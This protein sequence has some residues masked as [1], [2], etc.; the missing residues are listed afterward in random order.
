MRRHLE[1]SKA[2]LLNYISKHPEHAAK[3][4]MAA[5]EEE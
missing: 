4:A 2:A 3:M 5:Q 1:N